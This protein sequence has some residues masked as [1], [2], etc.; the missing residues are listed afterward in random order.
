MISSS[1]KIYERKYKQYNYSVAYYSKFDKV[2]NPKL[3]LRF[4]CR[5]INDI[6]IL[7]LPNKTGHS[8]LAKEQ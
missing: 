8:N 1:S 3:M 4:D 6:Q 5:Q 2:I 7:R